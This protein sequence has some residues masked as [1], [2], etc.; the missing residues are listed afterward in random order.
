MNDIQIYLALYVHG[1]SVKTGAPGTTQSQ[2][3]NSANRAG[4]AG[5]LLSGTTAPSWSTND[6][7]RALDMAR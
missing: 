3:G 5:S 4:L 2:S 6:E 7:G 1:S